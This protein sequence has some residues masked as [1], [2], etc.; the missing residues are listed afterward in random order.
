MPVFAMTARLQRRI[1]EDISDFLRSDRSFTVHLTFVYT[2]LMNSAIRKYE[3]GNCSTLFK[4]LP[5]EGL[6]KTT[7]YNKPTMSPDLNLKVSCHEF[8]QLAKRPF[9]SHS[10]PQ[11]V[12]QDCIRFSLLWI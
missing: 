7:Y 6:R 3:E 10:L 9:W 12:L 5:L 11:K 2:V 8:N 4:L 1:R